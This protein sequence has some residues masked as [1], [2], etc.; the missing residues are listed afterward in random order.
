MDELQGAVLRVK[1]KHLREWIELRRKNAELYNDLLKGTE[2]ILPVEPAFAKSVYYL[3]VVR[4]KNRDEL[5]KYL[6]DNEIA[7]G[8]HY[9]IPIH[10]QKSYHFLEYDKGDFPVA[11]RVSKEILSLP[12]YPELKHHQI[13]QVA[14]AI[15]EF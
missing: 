2:V 8:L 6:S 11:E 12:M 10:L 9:P 1:L 15:R 4:V 7:T 14:S 13:R 3:Y 5:Q